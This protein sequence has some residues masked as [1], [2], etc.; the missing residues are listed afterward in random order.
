MPRGRLLAAP[1]LLAF[2]A[3][4][5]SC[6][7]LPSVLV[8]SV[9]FRDQ[10]SGLA[11]STDMA[12]YLSLVDQRRLRITLPPPAEQ[13]RI[14]RVL[15]ALDDKI[16]LNRRMSQTLES[17]ARALFKSWFVDFEFSL[18]PP[19]ASW[20]VGCITDLADVVGG[21]TP[22]TAEPAYWDHGCHRFATPKDLATLDGPALFDTGQHITDAGL[23]KVSSG[24]LPAG[25][26]L[27]S[28]RAPIGY[29]AVCENPV[30][31]NQGFIALRPRA[32]VPSLFLYLWLETQTDEIQSRANGSTFLE[33]S[34]SS[35]RG[36]QLVKPPPPVLADF[37]SAT[38][39]LRSR[40]S[41]LSQERTQLASIRDC[42]LPELMSGRLAAN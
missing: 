22:P 17:M 27:L 14:A 19:A 24:L 25:T 5:C 12:P 40:L 38:L 8:G 18:Q 26:V 23:N 4:R 42:L 7:R 9:Q 35:F 32:G 36:I 29:R 28:S 41:R 33:I 2:L 39:G 15:G 6:A 34:K 1:E 21:N 13:E 20:P 16:E 3:P 31:I 10:L 30:A 37:G 11:S